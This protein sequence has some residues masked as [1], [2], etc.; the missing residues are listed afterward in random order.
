MLLVDAATIVIGTPT[1][2]GGPH[3]NVAYAANVA[4]L[5]KPKARFLSIIGSFGWGGKTVEQLSAMVPNLE[6]EVIPPVLCKGY[7][8]ASEFASLDRLAE[9]IAARHEELEAM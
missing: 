7:P 6:V 1:V 3:P 8:T 9:T 4:N 5:L 2:L